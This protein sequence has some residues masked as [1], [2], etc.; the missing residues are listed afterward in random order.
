M[1]KTG[2]MVVLCAAL[3]ARAGAESLPKEMQAKWTVDKA[4]VIKALP[5]YAAL[6][7]DKQKEMLT[8][9]EQQMPEM[10]VEFTGGKVLFGVASAPPQEATYRVLGIEKGVVRLEITSKSPDG[11]EDT[12]ETNAELLGADTLKLTK[13][14]EDA[15]LLFQR[16]K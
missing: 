12:D 14:G 1:R 3:A 5:S 16:V 13:K 11:K 9:A 7:P 8:Q 10:S 4:A 2:W 6:P 15:V